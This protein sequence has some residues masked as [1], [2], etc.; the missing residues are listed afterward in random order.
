MLREDFD[1]KSVRAI[2]IDSLAGHDTVH[3]NTR[4]PSMIDGGLGNDLLVGGGGADVIEGG[5]GEDD[6]Y[7]MGGDDILDGDGDSPVMEIIGG[8]DIVVG[9]EGM[10]Q[11]MKRPTSR[12]QAT[13]L[14]RLLPHWEAPLSRQ[15]LRRDSA[16]LL[17]FR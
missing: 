4:I 13:S 10:S 11:R 12:R 9:G 8:S 2:V 3:N 16:A 1:P 6:I 5:L 17:T 7:G 15:L 14:V